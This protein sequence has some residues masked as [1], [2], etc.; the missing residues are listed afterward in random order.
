MLS[1]FIEHWSA[2]QPG[3]I[4]LQWRD[5]QAALHTLTWHQFAA[6]TDHAVMRLASLGIGRGDRVAYLGL[7]HPEML[8]MLMACARLGAIL[9]PLN[10]RLSVGE[11]QTITRHAECALMIAD[12]AMQPTAQAITPARP[13]MPLVALSETVPAGW[14]AWA[15]SAQAPFLPKQPG[16]ANDDVLLV[17]T[18]GTTGQPK[19]AVHTQRAMQANIEAAIAGQQLNTQDHA[20]AVLPLFHVGGLCIQTLP[21]LA[22]GGCVTLH[23]RFE[24]GAWLREVTGQ[25]FPV[26]EAGSPGR[27]S[28]SLLVPAVIRALTEQADWA[29]AD[30]SSL[31]FVNAGSSV[32]PLSQLQAFHARGIPVSQVYGSTETGPVSL[33]LHPADAIRKEGSAGRAAQGVTVQLTDEAGNA[34]ASGQVGEIWLRAANLARGYWLEP[35]HAAFAGGWYRT[36][37]LAMQDSEGFYTVVGRAK[38]MIISGGENIY[39][40]EIENLLAGHAQ[41]GECAVVGVA[42]ARWGEIPVLAATTPMTHLQLQ[43]EFERL[44]KDTLARY[45]WPKRYAVLPELPKTALGKVIKARLREILE[46]AHG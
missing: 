19:G 5:S 12:A 11:L 41:I 13:L 30:L 9:V 38:D 45:K 43:G 46:E 4:A 28:T 32:I 21:T 40:A 25:G 26:A 14:F 37:D 20:L 36:G 31:R 44:A 22:A 23:A 42:D 24:P 7:N 27:P 18:S 1:R 33:V 10:F 2:L 8:A 6:R 34:V 29:T 16:T 15:G 17:Y 39:P 3:R 35:D